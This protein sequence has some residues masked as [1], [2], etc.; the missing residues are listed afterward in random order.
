MRGFD[1]A[2]VLKRWVA[3]QAMGLTDD[4]PDTNGP[5][6]PLTLTGPA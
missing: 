6:G 2:T 4:A 1:N 5:M 3:R